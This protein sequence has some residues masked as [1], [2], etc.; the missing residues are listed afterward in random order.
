MVEFLLERGADINARQS[1]DGLHWT[2]QLKNQKEM[3]QI[4]VQMEGKT[5]RELIDKT[6]V[7]PVKGLL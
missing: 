5:D 6:S 4:F 1:T 3:I 7:T 2:W